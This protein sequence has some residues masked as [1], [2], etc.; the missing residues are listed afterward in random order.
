MSHLHRIL[1]NK[2]QK[3]DCDQQIRYYFL[4]KN[5]RLTICRKIPSNPFDPFGDFWS[6]NIFGPYD[7]YFDPPKNWI[8]FFFKRKWRLCGHSVVWYLFI[9]FSIIFF[10]CAYWYKGCTVYITKLKNNNDFLSGN[11]AEYCFGISSPASIMKKNKWMKI[12]LSSPKQ[13]RSQD[14][15]VWTPLTFFTEIF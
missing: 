8:R 2:Y 4:L 9:S 3:I 10:F 1:W 14:S 13:D 11:I 12:S 5:Q 15:G 6:K 7:R